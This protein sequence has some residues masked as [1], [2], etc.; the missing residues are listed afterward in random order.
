MVKVLECERCGFKEYLLAEEKSYDR[1]PSCQSIV[2]A[3]EKNDLPTQLQEIINVA[4]Q[5]FVYRNIKTDNYS[6]FFDIDEL[7]KTP[8]EVISSFEKINFYPFI[9]REKE[10][11]FVIL[12]SCLLYT[13]P[14]PRDS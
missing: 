2:I 5:N 6:V 3:Q 4:N 9:R 10:K 13:S 14:S 1:C 11:L 12:R 8:E 7:Y